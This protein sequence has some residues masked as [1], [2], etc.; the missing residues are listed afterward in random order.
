[1]RG[2]DLPGE[3]ILPND[4]YLHQRIARVSGRRWLAYPA[5]DGVGAVWVRN[6]ADR[7]LVGGEREALERLACARRNGLQ[8]F[9]AVRAAWKDAGAAGCQP[10][11]AGT[12]GAA[13]ERAGRFLFSF[14]CDSLSCCHSSRRCLFRALSGDRGG[15]SRSLL[16]AASVCVRR[17]DVDGIC[18]RPDRYFSWPRGHG[19]ELLLADRLCAGR[20]VRAKSFTKLRFS[21][22]VQFICI[23]WWFSAALQIVSND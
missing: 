10:R 13:P 21:L 16:R 18:G 9:Y 23:G 17:H 7:S 2:P 5:R 11:V 1:M 6:F 4:S 3:K 14:F 15:G 20:A 12:A 22:G 8:W 19:P